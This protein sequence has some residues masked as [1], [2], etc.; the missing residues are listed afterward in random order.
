[1]NKIVFLVAV[2]VPVIVISFGEMI[3]WG[4]RGVFKRSESSWVC[5]YY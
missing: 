3:C 1:M 5:D 4:F 2:I